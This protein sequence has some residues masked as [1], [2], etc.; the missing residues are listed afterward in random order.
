MEKQERLLEWLGSDG[1][2]SDPR[3]NSVW[4]ERNLL[5]LMREDMLGKHMPPQCG[6]TVSRTID[7][8]N[9]YVEHVN[10]H[11]YYPS[12]DMIRMRREVVKSAKFAA[13]K[14]KVFGM[15]YNE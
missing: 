6:E 4:E 15:S 2:E 11:G 1:A 9:R 14:A 10:K 5:V 12:E 13:K 8:Y 7:L 3:Y